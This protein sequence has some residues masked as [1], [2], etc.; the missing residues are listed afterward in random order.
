MPSTAELGI[1]SNQQ[2]NAK[3]S[4]AYQ[5][6]KFRLKNIDLYG[7]HLVEKTTKEK[8]D[9]K[10]NNHWRNPGELG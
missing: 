2:V 8:T 9:T 6:F 1:E 4:S 10:S 3:E 7:K 5:Q